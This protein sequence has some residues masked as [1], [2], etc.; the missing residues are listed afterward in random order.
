MLTNA[1][2]AALAQVNALSVLFPRKTASSLSIP[3]RAWNAA[4]APVFALSALLLL[5]ESDKKQNNM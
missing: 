4:L 5:T 1:S 2:A 3:I